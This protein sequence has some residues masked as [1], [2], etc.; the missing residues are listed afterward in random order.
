MPELVD[1]MAPGDDPVEASVR[2]AELPMPCRVDAPPV[3]CGAP[4]VVVVLVDAVDA[5]LDVDVDAPPSRVAVV[6]HG[7]GRGECDDGRGHRE[8]EQDASHGG[9]SRVVGWWPRRGAVVE[10]RPGDGIGC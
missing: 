5:P 8:A 1:G 3:R 7:G 2:A 4:G 9:I 10:L 6:R